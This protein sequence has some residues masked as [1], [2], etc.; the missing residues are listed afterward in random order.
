MMSGRVRRM[1]QLIDGV[2]EYSRAGRIDE[3]RSQ[4]DLNDIVA[5]VIE[6]VVPDDRIR[7]TLDTSFPS[8]TLSPARIRQVFQNLLDN[9]VKFM[10]KPQGEIHLGCERQGEYWLFWVADNGP[11]IEAQYF[12]RIFEIFQTLFPRDHVDSTGLGL[13]I[14]KRI[15][16]SYAGRVWLGSVVGQGSKFYFTLPV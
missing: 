2:L 5:E 16:E 12:E 7:V 15:I 6:D 3:N 1:E 4:V 14:I 11:G 8:L 10:D 9:A 13:A